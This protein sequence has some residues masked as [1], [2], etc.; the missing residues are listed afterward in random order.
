MCM[1]RLTFYLLNCYMPPVPFQYVLMRI[2]TSRE[3]DLVHPRNENQCLGYVQD[4]EGGRPRGG[5][6]GEGMG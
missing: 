2:A 6:G 4:L 5:G 1:D 3:S